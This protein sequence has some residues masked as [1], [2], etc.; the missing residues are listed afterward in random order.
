MDNLRRHHRPVETLIIEKVPYRKC[1]QLKRACHI[2][3]D[4][5]RG[6]FGISSL[7]SLSQGKPV[8]AGL[9]AWNI[10]CIRK[11]TQADD[12]PWVIARNEE[13][14]E[15]RMEALISDPHL[16]QNIGT[17]SRRFMESHWAETH[18]LKILMEVYE[19]L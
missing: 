10:G 12:L 8:I 15:Q 14:L 5:M 4:H 13:E 7:E 16:R 3:F 19:A 1:L 17:E 2:V 18:V 6:W 11:F 9:D